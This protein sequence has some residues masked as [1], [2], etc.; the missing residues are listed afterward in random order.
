MNTLKALLQKNM[1]IA[2]L[3][4]FA[5]GLPLLLVGKTLQV[6]MTGAGVDLK[7]IGFFALA[8][9]PY[10]LKFVWAPIFDRYSL[11]FMGR[12]RGWLMVIQTA[13]LFTIGLMALLQPE[14]HLVIMAAL[15]L[16]I[17]F[18]SASQD[19]VVDAY[20]RESLT[21]EELGVGS[22]LYVY[23]YHMALWVTGGL[24]LIMADHM[25]WAAVYGIM[26]GTMLFAIGSTLFANEPE[27]NVPPPRTMKEPVIQPLTDFFR[28]PEV[29]GII[30]FVLLY[31]VG[32]TLAGAMANPF[33]VQLGFSNTEIGSIVKTFGF[34]ATLAGSMIG[35]LWILKMGI[36]RSLL[37]F[38]VLQAV[39]TAGFAV[40]ATLGPSLAGLTWVIAFE[41]LTSG[42]G[43]AA[44]VAFMGV[45][46]NKRFTATQ[47]ALL[48]SLMGVPRVIFSSYTGVMA[49]RMGWQGFF[50]FCTLAA[51][52]G[53]LL[54]AFMLMKQKR[55][56]AANPTSR[57]AT[58]LAEA[59]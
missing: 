35:G 27:V 41:N 40:L 43:T 50:I 18:L 4:G 28:R 49:E 30:A 52:P 3:M 16:V 37:L 17:S 29:W 5:S 14:Q 26:A 2:L 54:L 39:S 19:I 47:Y 36:N 48:T 11:P 21:D 7:T 42:M 12:R 23:G 55:E 38:G 34:F 24:A 32:D 22:T 31:K 46:T 25:S 1:L 57:V 9:L 15:C 20:R 59:Q 53:M 58:E 45:Q 8:G 33:Y 10:T 6:W 13:L 51:I 56:R 44:F